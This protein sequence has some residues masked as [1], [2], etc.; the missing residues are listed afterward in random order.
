[1]T[2]VKGIGEKRALQLKEMGIDTAN[3]LI[4]ESSEK[5]AQKLKISPKIT[6]KWKLDAEQLLKN[7]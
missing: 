2:Q 6:E 3:D 1:M 4:N 5:I 7:P